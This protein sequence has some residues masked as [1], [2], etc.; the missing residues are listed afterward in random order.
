MGRGPGS[1]Y[2]IDRFRSIISSA[3]ETCRRK[4]GSTCLASPA[5]ADVPPEG[6][7][8][9]LPIIVCPPLAPPGLPASDAL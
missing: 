4:A 5:K 9:P 3:L 7:L 8:P 2:E 6:A 1:R